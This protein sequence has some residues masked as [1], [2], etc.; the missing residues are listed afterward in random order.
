MQIA[1]LLGNHIPEPIDLIN[2][3]R[4]GI[5]KS[6]ALSV[7]HHMGIS[8]KELALLLHLTPRTLQRMSEEDVLPPVASGQ[9]IELA[10]IFGRAIE[11]LGEEALARQWLR[12]PLQA[13][14]QT[15]PL[16]LMDT[17]VGIQWVLALLGRIE[18]GLYS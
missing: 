15:T 14:N 2:L 1:N 7:Q 18:H 11:V 3:T 10:R 8:Q 12:T 6:E 13:L 5:S 9:L 4:K 17:P 16:A